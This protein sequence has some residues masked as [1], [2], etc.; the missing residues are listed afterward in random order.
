MQENP[1]TESETTTCDE[2]FAA[3]EDSC[4]D[5]GTE[6]DIE[7]QQVCIFCNSKRKKHTGRWQT[8]HSSCAQD[9]RE[10]I[11]SQ[12]TELND[13]ILIRKIE[14]LSSQECPISYHRICVVQY[15]NKFQ[16]HITSQ[17]EKTNWH[18]KRDTASIAF[19]K[20]CSFVE[21]NIMRNKH[22]YY[23]DFLRTLY[24][25]YL[26]DEVT[27]SKMSPNTFCTRYLEERLVKKYPKGI[28][29]IQ[30]NKR[31]IV[32]PYTGVVL[33]DSDFSLL[34]DEEIVQ[35]AA[36]ILRRSIREL[37]KKPIPEKILVSDLMNGE[38][39]V[40][41]IL[42]DFYNIL[43][44]GGAYRRKKNPQCQRLSKSFSEDVIHAVWSGK[45]M[46]SKHIVLGLTLKGLTNSKKIINIINRY[47]HA[48]AILRCK[49]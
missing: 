22:V 11:K 41:D 14:C 27:D 18:M 3:S 37:E 46:P 43:L 13:V 23:L 21:E 17:K 45:M 7:C 15:Q 32:K 8:L 35:K 25:E 6:K 44:S 9:T 10:N 42:T 48:L 29:V 49:N 4:D 34:Q 16:S 5:P 24:A 19:D 38:C 39:K 28:S 1:A 12:A 33:K 47:G 31:K 26:S 30:N 36:V 20:I 40:P 2:S